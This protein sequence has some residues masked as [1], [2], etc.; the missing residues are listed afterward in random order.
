MPLREGTIDLNFAAVAV[1]SGFEV[2]AID[3]GLNFCPIFGGQFIRSIGMI[4]SVIAL[5]IPGRLAVGP[6][7]GA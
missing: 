6:L 5:P 4:E 7:V 1:G 3:S 2:V